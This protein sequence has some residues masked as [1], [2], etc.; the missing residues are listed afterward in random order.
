MDRKGGGGID[1][2]REGES[3]RGQW[4]GGDG[5]GSNRD[6]KEVAVGS[7]TTWRGR[8][9]GQQL[10]EGG[11]WEVGNGEGEEG[12]EVGWGGGE[13]GGGEISQIDMMGCL[14]GH[15]L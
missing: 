8:W 14:G 9:R 6:G 2:N 4:G 13:E 10:G 7:G 1:G 3:G 5:E 11:R 15:R 12:K